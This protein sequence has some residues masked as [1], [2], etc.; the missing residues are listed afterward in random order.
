MKIDIKVPSVGESITEGVLVAWHKAD[1]AAVRVDEPLFELETDK[2]T[3]T[4]AAEGAGA[5]HIAVAAGAT[6]QIGQ[7]VGHIDTAAGT[8][9]TES[10]SAPPP[11]TTP[12]PPPP[13]APR[14]APALSPEPRPLLKGDGP[15]LAPPAGLPTLRTGLQR[16]QALDALSPAVRRLVEEHGLDPSAI[17]ATGKGGRLTK[18]DV[19]RHLEAHPAASAAAPA[20]AAHAL[21]TASSPPAATAAPSSP[22]AAA[23]AAPSSASPAARQTRTKMSRLRARIAER[24]LQAQQT[25]A[26]LTTFNEVDMSAVIELRER[27]KKTFEQKHGVGLGFMSFFVKA[28]VDA[29]RAVPALNA[30]IDG[31]EIVQNHFYDI[32]VAV[33][34][35]RGLVVPVLR[36][37]DRL[38]LAGIE[39]GIADL[40]GRARDGKLELSELLGGV[41]TISNGGVYG[42]LLSTPILNPPQSGILGMHGIKKRP[43]VV[44]DQ[45]VARPMMYLAVSYDH[46][47][48]DGAEAVTFLRRIVDVVEHP[49]LDLLEV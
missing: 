39:R 47:L 43:V 29:L 4:A 7:V 30:Q 8:A 33:G 11:A 16:Q 28:A 1:G 2:V 44:G 20:P 17:A 35:P 45:I 18:A 46:R 40:A 32:G 15:P 6:V 24:L 42:S 49:G 26:I 27:F 14:A 9:T 5:L 23:A 38:S 12:A 19:L 34:T 48:V 41:F 13:P 22:A 36:D 25:A 10:P 21:S 3:L 31:D 37:C